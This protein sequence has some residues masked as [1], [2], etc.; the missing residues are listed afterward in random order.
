MVISIQEGVHWVQDGWG[1]K[2]T[3]NKNIMT[4]QIWKYCSSFPPEKA[5][6]NVK[7]LTN[8]CV[9]WN[10]VP[11]TDFANTCIGP[12]VCLPK[13]RRVW[14]CMTKKSQTNKQ[15]KNL[16]VLHTSSSYD[17]EKSK[18]VVRL[19]QYS[20]SIRFVFSICFS[21]HRAN[22]RCC[23]NDWTNIR[24]LYSHIREIS[25]VVL[26]QENSCQAYVVWNKGMLIAQ[27]SWM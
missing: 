16:N 23:F 15:T 4:I 25:K 2:K 21:P 18:T 3:K 27:I 12:H 9:I 22:R 26:I 5:C 24:F 11:D 6:F 17:I 8:I 10:S 13:C 1:E 14:I 7:I 20:R 19:S